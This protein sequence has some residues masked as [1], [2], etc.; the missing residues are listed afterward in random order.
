M[1][2]REGSSSARGGGVPNSEGYLNQSFPGVKK[3]G[4]KGQKPK[5]YQNG[6]GT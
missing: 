6:W 2:L 4:D 1:K 5:G 3:R